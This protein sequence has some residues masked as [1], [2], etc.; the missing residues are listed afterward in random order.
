[1]VFAALWLVRNL[2]VDIQRLPEA[3]GLGSPFRSMLSTS[4]TAP[5]DNLEG[6]LKDLEG[7]LRP[8]DD[9]GA[10]G[11]DTRVDPSILL[12]VSS[13]WLF[14]HR[15][16]ILAPDEAPTAAVVVVATSGEGS[17]GPIGYSQAIFS[18]SWPGGALQ[19]HRRLL[20][21]FLPSV[22]PP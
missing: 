12:W 10:E 9:V 2:A 13:Y 22:A 6:A 8:G 15:V 3:A 1:M 21:C 5:G 20:P 4:P 14:P 16:R 11:G 18:R 19:A 17:A 7:R